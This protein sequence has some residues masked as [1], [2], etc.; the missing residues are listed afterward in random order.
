MFWTALAGAY[1]D[2]IQNICADFNATQDEWKVVPEY[3]GNYY[4]IAAK[5]QA[6][7]L[8]GSEPDIVQMECSRTPLFSDYGAFAELSDMLANVG[9]DAKEYFYDGF[10]VDCDWAR[11]ST[12]CR[13]T[14]PRRCSTTTRPSSTRWV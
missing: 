6:S 4:D 12:R 7:L 1:N 11:A 8:D 13:S 2:V 14:V 9:L 5:L 3:Q 10:M